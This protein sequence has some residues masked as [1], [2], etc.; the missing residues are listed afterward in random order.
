MLPSLLH[1]ELR[2][3]SR[4]DRALLESCCHQA[5]HKREAAICT[6]ARIARGE[7]CTTRFV[8]SGREGPERNSSD[9]DEV[10]KSYRSH[11]SDRLMKSEGPR[12]E[13]LRDIGWV[14][15]LSPAPLV[16]PP[17]P[18]VQSWPLRTAHQIA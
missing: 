14:S 6:S 1:A 9:A 11:P 2:A 12:L 7:H 4:E 10:R 8:S 17:S 5:C 16:R 13:P 3:S 18:I 15:A